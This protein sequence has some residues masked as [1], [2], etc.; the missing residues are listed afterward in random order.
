MNK[1]KVRPSDIQDP[2]LREICEKHGTGWLLDLADMKC[3]EP[4]YVPKRDKL[5][6]KSRDRLILKSKDP[7]NI[8]AKMYNLTPRRIRQIKQKVNGQ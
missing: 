8:L 2:I 1:I 5:E 6:E 7:V 4:L 3:S